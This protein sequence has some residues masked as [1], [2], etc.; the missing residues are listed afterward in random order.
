[1]SCL[2]SRRGYPLAPLQAVTCTNHS[3]QPMAV[4]IAEHKYRSRYNYRDR[5]IMQSSASV[6]PGARRTGRGRTSPR[7]CDCE[8]SAAA[9]CY[10]KVKCGC[11]ANEILVSPRPR[12]ALRSRRM[13]RTRITSAAQDASRRSVHVIAAEYSGSVRPASTDAH[14]R[15]ALHCLRKKGG[16][17]S[18]TFLIEQAHGAD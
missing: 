8:P 5:Y 16:H 1:M 13:F 7:Q 11:A 3:M 14:T 4:G 17:T 6:G 18:A 12:T 2:L 10:A 9:W 15:H